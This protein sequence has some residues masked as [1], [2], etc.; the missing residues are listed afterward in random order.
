MTKSHCFL[1]YSILGLKSIGEGKNEL[2]KN[3]THQRH[4]LLANVLTR[5]K[6][7]TCSINLS[8]H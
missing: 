6:L 2:Q 3:S 7:F 5:K 4:S 1:P 8:F